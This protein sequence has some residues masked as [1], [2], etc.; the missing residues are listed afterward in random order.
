MRLAAATAA[1]L[2][3]WV[4][5]PLIITLES[6]FI[7]PTNC[8]ASAAWR[9]LR[10]WSTKRQR[11]LKPAGTIGINDVL[12]EQKEETMSLWDVYIGNARGMGKCAYFVRAK[13]FVMASRKAPGRTY[14]YLRG[15]VLPVV[16]GRGAAACG[17]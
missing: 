4:T 15:T 13:L 3:N 2:Q 1:G 17:R 6:V 5:T 16:A 11:T 14:L 9:W 12:T 7:C 10:P 8:I